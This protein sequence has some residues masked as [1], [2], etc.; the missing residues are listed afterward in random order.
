MTCRQVSIVFVR[1]DGGYVVDL[2]AKFQKTGQV[3]RAE[4]YS[5]RAIRVGGLN[6]C[7]LSEL[8][9]FEVIIQNTHYVEVWHQV[10]ITV[11]FH[12]GVFRG[13][14]ETAPRLL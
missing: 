3:R 10:K 5:S 7:T 8:P 6:I 11:S 2:G 4:R 9:T 14:N 1:A 13:L 12:I